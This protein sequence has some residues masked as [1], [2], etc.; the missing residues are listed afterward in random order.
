MEKSPD[1][2]RT[3]SEVADLL[4]TPAHVL[5][6]WESRFPQ[7]R[8]VKRAGGRRYYRPA[9][10]ALLAGIR[11]L[12]H[13]Q[14]MTIRGVQKLL[15]EQGVRHVS[16]LGGTATGL[17]FEGTVLP[18]GADAPED[19]APE[20][21]PDAAMEADAPEAPLAE[22]D[23]ADAGR[24][25]PWPGPATPMAVATPDPAAP[26]EPVADTAAQD[27]A[28]A[29]PDDAAIAPPLPANPSAAPAPPRTVQADLFGDLP[30]FFRQADP[31]GD[32]APAPAAIVHAAAEPATPTEPAAPE[33][34][35]P[36]A[37]DAA[38]MAD[39]RSMVVR[40]RNLPP[41]ALAQA[42]LGPAVARLSALHDRMKAPPSG[43]AS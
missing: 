18:D 29:V 26:S 24:I 7:I 17:A 41:G 31:A 34:A 16:A 23:D 30:L 43:H 22:D 21:V 28:A 5:R 6:F 12:L 40:I 37:V 35:A 8:P 1:A 33:P 27:A 42:G 4:E 11:H 39:I 3:I 15:R 14:G 13:E 36:R 9:D 2:F 32:D 19:A 25:I 38:S 20:G 10:I